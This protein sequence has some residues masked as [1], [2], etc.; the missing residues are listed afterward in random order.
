MSLLSVFFDFA[1]C[2]KAV[3]GAA[4]DEWKCDNQLEQEPDGD[5]D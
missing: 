4:N 3:Y 2:V 5:G 1:A